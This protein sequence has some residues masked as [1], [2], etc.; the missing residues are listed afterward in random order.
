MGTVADDTLAHY[1]RIRAEERERCAKMVE[2]EAERILSKQKP[3]ADPLGM[4]DTINLNL[5]MMAA[6]LPELAAKIREADKSR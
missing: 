1:E 3:D 4:D 5:R 6:I 2:A